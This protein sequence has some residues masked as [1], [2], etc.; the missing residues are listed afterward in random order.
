MPSKFEFTT[1]NAEKFKDFRFAQAHSPEKVKKS[2]PQVQPV[3]TKALPSH[4]KTMNAN[5]FKRH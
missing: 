3:Q 5:E 2:A 1:T 4:F